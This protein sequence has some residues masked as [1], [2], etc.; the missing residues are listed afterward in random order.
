[1]GSRGGAGFAA[2]ENGRVRMELQAAYPAG[3]VKRLTRTFAFDLAAGSLQ[4]QDLFEQPAGPVEENRI[5]RICPRMTPRGILLEQNGTAALLLIG[6]KEEAENAGA[7]R[8][9]VR[10]LRLTH[11]N[12]AGQDE[13]VYAIRWELPGSDGQGGRTEGGFCIRYLC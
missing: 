5:T 13:P 6:P 4:V 9:R 2:Q 1:M 7:A 10:V 11:R 3:L 12:H 8:P